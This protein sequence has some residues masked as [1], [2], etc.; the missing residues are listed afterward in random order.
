M[1]PKAWKPKII[2]R[3]LGQFGALWI[4]AVARTRIEGSW[5]A[6][7][8]ITTGDYPEIEQKRILDHGAKLRSEVADAIFPELAAIRYSN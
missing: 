3:S 7:V 4:T 1:S 8:G 2:Q 6:Y 5:G